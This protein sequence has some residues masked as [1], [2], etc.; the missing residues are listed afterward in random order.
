MY[1]F[2]CLFVLI[3]EIEHCVLYLRILSMVLLINCI[4]NFSDFG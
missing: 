3:N 2:G 1:N 4:I